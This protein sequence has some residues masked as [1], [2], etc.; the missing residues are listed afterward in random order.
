MT[1]EAKNFEVDA[2]RDIA[3]VEEDAKD[4]T[5]HSLSFVRPLPHLS[6]NSHFYRA[7]F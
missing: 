2:R 7:G 5:E 3:Q 6:H 4:V 1:H